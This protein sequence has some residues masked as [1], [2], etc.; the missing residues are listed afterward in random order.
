MLEAEAKKKWCPM[1]RVAAVN[2]G[3]CDVVSINR[4][5]VGAVSDKGHEGSFNCLGSAC[6]LWVIDGLALT[7]EDGEP[8]G[9]CG[10]VRL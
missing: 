9:H 3:S 2:L 7:S 4:V 1:V 8:P 6:A 5:P 10:L